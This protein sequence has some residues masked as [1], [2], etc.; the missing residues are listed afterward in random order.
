MHRIRTLL[1]DDEYLALNL[2][3]EYI[4]NI[5]DLEIVAKVKSPIR[6]LDVLNSEHVDLMFQKQTLIFLF[7]PLSQFS[8]SEYGFLNSPESSL[9]EDLE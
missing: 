7:L 5:P 8:H 9:E 4:K 1:V 3:E 2:L 6:A